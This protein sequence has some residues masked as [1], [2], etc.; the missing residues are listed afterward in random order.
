MIVEW[1][2]L[3]LGRSLAP[4]SWIVWL[5][6]SELAQ[7]MRLPITPLIAVQS[8]TA[9][10][11]DSTPQSIT[12]GGM[13]VSGPHLYIPDATWASLS[14]LSLREIRALQL[15]VSAGHGHAAT[16]PVPQAIQLAMRELIAYWHQHRGEGYSLLRSVP[17]DVGTGGGYQTSPPVPQWVLRRL[18]NY[19]HRA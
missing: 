16:T 14:G 5:D 3:E 10:L 4:A 8:A 19:Y 7:Y 13:S 18:A 17:Q 6:R 2:E 9:Y 12:V 15:V 11:S 1:L